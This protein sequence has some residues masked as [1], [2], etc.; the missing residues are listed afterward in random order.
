ML[1]AIDVSTVVERDEAEMRGA[2]IEQQRANTQCR[3]NCEVG[4]ICPLSLRERV[5]GVAELKRFGHRS[6]PHPSPLPT[7]E[8]AETNHP[9][10]FSRRYPLILSSPILSW[11]IESRCRIVTV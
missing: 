10:S 9:A 2:G 4:R 7:G 6:P 11:V 5:R 8:G 3:N 1:G